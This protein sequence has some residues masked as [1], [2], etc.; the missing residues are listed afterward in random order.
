MLPQTAFAGAEPTASPRTTDPWLAAGV[1]VFAPLLLCALHLAAIVRF[2]Y[3]TLAFLFAGYLYS[4]RS[5]WY[6]GF[7]V[8]LF[9][10]APLVRRLVDEQAGFDISSPVLLAPYLACSFAALA[11][12]DVFGR[13]PAVEAR[14]FIAVNLCV[15]YGLILA[16]A[17]ERL[18]SGLIDA[19]KWS[20]GPLF[21]LYLIQSADRAKS[22]SSS[23]NMA[24]LVALPAMSIYGISQYISPARWDADWMT[25]I[26][27]FDPGL[28]SMG[29]PLPYEVRVFSTMNSP[30][31]FAALAMVGILVTLQRRTAISLPLVAL[32]TTALLL[33][34]YRAVWFGTLLGVIYLGFAGSAGTRLRI[35][36]SAVA[37][38]FLMTT[39][40]FVPEFRQAITQR[41]DSI[42]HLQSDRSG[43]DRWHQYDEFFSNDSVEMIVGAGLAVDGASRRLDGK[44]SAVI[45]SGIIVIFTAL[46]IV[47]G[48][49]LLVSL[50]GSLAISFS[51]CAESPSANVGYRAAAIASFCQLPFG[52][53]FVGES[54]F[55]VWLFL[56]LAAANAN[57]GQ[58][59]ARSVKRQKA[60]SASP[61][62]PAEPATI[63]QGDLRGA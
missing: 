3:P 62:T 11:F 61:S 18:F 42:S 32:M 55:C 2:S 48:S 50:A 5:S 24:L 54:G 37:V 16:V 22:V 20:C 36:V 41:I 47:V 52:A 56:G 19:M 1:A 30:G 35:I 58:R 33:T 29:N 14:P 28:L 17:N 43:E 53:I 51:R 40:S 38:V 57:V 44:K 49:L 45:D 39:F 10:A 46:G 59:A 31:S 23:V 25:N 15:G 27:L 9:C 4:R 12:F 6:A 26:Q 63:I 60:A 34:Q 13:K 8:W 21:A 7:V